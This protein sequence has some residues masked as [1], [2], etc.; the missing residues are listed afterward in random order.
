MGNKIVS[1]SKKKTTPIKETITQ[2]NKL[3][4]NEKQIRSF[5][6]K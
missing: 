2:N 4:S 3:Y 6:S 5:E 1:E